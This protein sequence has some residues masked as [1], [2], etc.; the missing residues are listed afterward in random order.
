MSSYS[1]VNLSCF[2]LL[3]LLITHWVILFWQPIS[4]LDFI[5]AV[6]FIGLEELDFFGT[7]KLKWQSLIW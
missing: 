6:P 1:L 3:L 7:L 5:L 4:S 2:L